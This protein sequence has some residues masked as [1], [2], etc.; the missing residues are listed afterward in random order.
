MD[1][2]CQFI[3][4]MSGLIA[5]ERDAGLLVALAF[6]NNSIAMVKSTKLDGTLLDWSGIL[7]IGKGNESLLSKR[8]K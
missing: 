1:T 8:P 5:V 3:Q 4:A 7:I 2:H 6:L